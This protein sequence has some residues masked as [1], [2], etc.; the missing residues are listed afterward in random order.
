MKDSNARITRWS[1]SLQPY[2]FTVKYCP[3]AKNKVADFL[4]RIPE[5][6]NTEIGLSTP[7]L[8]GVEV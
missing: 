2:Q 4:S 3:G 7:V 6:V 5:D 1:V 8:G